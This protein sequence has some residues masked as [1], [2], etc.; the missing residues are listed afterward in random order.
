[1]PSSVIMNDFAPS[2]QCKVIAYISLQFHFLG[3]CTCTD[4][5]FIHERLTACAC[6]LVSYVHL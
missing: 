1:M 5:Y 4:G 2:V 3:K 6:L